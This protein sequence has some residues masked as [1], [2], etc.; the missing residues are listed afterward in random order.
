MKDKHAAQLLQNARH[1]ITST[2]SLCGTA[3]V[4]KNSFPKVYVLCSFVEHIVIILGSTALVGP[5][6]PQTNVASDLYPG[7]PPAN[8]HNLGFLASS[9]TPS[10]HLDLRNSNLFHARSRRPTCIVS[11]RCRSV[12]PTSFPLGFVTIFFYGVGL[13]ALRPTPNME[14]QGNLFVWV[15]TRPINVGRPYQEPTLLPA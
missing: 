3:M 4:G 7:H 13:S 2:C 6:S 8:F 1:P 15:I 5:W 9:S 12:R 14:G 10:I 11:C